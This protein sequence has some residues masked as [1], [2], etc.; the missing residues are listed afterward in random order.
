MLFIQIVII[1]IL[2]IFV[3]QQPYLGI[4][5]TAASL[6]V[7]DLLPP[8]PGFTSLISL[9]GIIT[10]IGF[11]LHRAKDLNKPLFRLGAVHILGLLFIGWMYISN[12]Q[13]T[14]FGTTRNWFFTFLQLWMLTWLAGELLDTSDKH[15]VFMWVF[16]IASIV[17]AV[18]TIQ[19]GRIG[20]NIYSSLRASGLADNANAAARY[21]VVSMVFLIYLRTVMKNHLLRLLANGGIIAIFLGVFFTVS[22]TGILLLVAAIGLMILLNPGRKYRFQI[23]FIFIITLLGLWFLSDNITG[24]VSSIVPSIIQGNDT[25]GLRYHLWQ[26]GW[27]MWLDNPLQGVGIGMYPEQLINY[28]RDTV[29]IIYLIP[30]LVTHNMYIQVLAETGI[31]GFSLFALMLMI[32]L[33]SLWNTGKVG[34]DNMLF[35]RN[36]WFI[37]FLLMLLGGM[38]KSDQIDKLIWL[39]MG[40]SVFFR[41]N[42]QVSEPE[43]ATHNKWKQGIR[44]TPKVL[45]GKDESKI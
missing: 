40:I 3:L 8:I 9:L 29:P 14:W 18:L 2:T 41:N 7:I 22:R 5:F 10:L 32:S 31:V 17:S 21:F 12:P 45:L 24:I 43:T 13:A 15:H 11:L 34:N 25:I 26:A 44:T 23:F 35:L 37:V 6:P 1:A 33:R 30:G 38:T 27:R 19:S 20:E 28:A 36:A 4:V 39:V 42:A 16:S